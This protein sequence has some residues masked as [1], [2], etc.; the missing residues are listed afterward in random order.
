MNDNLAVSSEYNA[1]PRLGF[2]Q[3]LLGVVFAPGK[4]M[5]ELEQKPRVLFGLLL[6]LIVPLISIFATFPMFKEYFRNTTEAA[7]ANGNQANQMTPEMLDSYVNVMA[8]ASPLL[9]SL[10]V[11]VMLLVEALV[12]WAIFKL[13]KGQG[14]FK[15]YL[16]ILGYT[17]VIALL[18]TIPF[19]IVTIL[20]G[21]Y[22]E[23]SYT[24]LAALI[25]E[26]KG[27]F[28]YG[29]AKSFDVFSIWQYIVVSIGVVTV[30]KL[31]KNKVYIIIACI[32]IA[33]AL[34][35]GFSEVKAAAAVM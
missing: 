13:F 17:S 16:S 25:P 34:I 10:I 27:S 5:A 1:I 18:G 21:S 35:A 26:M 15:H 14:T 20:T 6:T 33:L 2:F 31:S 3:R 24:S 29:M 8:I 7:L 9:G 12:L 4:L 11:G 32:F 23:I 19:I 30:S 28:I 22:A